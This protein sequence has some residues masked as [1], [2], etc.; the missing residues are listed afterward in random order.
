[1]S[2]FIFIC[3]CSSP[4]VPDFP[5]PRNFFSKNKKN[6]VHSG[7]FVLKGVYDESNISILVPVHD[8]S[9]MQFRTR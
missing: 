3:P 9:R 6:N 8:C 7:D 5:P 2:I 1:M 4:E